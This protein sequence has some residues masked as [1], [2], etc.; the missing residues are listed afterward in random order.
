M[1][2]KKRSWAEI[3]EKFEKGEGIVILGAGGDLQ[4]WVDGI[5][6]IL[7]EEK[8]TESDKFEDN[9]S[10]VF[11]SESTGGRTDLHMIFAKESK[12]DIGKLA[13][14][15]LR[16]GDCSWLS[17]WFVNYRSHYDTNESKPFNRTIS[18]L[19]EITIDMSDLDD[20]NDYCNEFN[21]IIKKL[22]NNIDTQIGKSYMSVDHINI[23]SICDHNACKE[24]PDE[25]IMLGDII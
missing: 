10:D 3:H 19:T 17:D 25:K 12:L 8:I 7:T 11:Y 24:Y 14:W 4:E 13:M 16:F 18:I 5:F 6:K 1:E 23:E 21:E 9:F 22:R 15:R 20:E 2:I